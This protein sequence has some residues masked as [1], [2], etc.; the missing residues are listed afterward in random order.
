MKRVSLVFA[1]VLMVGLMVLPER[2]QAN[3]LVVT[4]FRPA[5]VSTVTVT[6]AHPVVI[7]QVVIVNNTFVRPNFISPVIF[8]ASRVILVS[9]VVASP[10]AASPVLGGP[11]VVAPVSQR[12]W[13]PGFWQWT[14]AEW[15]W[16]SGQWG[17]TTD[18]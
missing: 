15:T 17:W 12:V 9:P 14:G 7:N 11:V 13:V 3:H 8:P 16:A 2:A 5:T 10:V 6:H 1:L 4:R 18:Q